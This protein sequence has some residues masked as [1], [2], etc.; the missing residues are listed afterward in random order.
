MLSPAEAARKV[1]QKV[2]VQYVVAS[3][4]GT[5]NLYLN[6]EKNYQNKDNFAVVLGPK[7]QTG[8]WERAAAQKVVGQTVRATGTVKLYKDAPQLEVADE[9]QIE[10]VE[11]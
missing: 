10:I 4:G 9:K 5:T 6:S 11:P 7:L 2:T 3:V 1:G 8:K